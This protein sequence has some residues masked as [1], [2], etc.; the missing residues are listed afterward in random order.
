MKVR[1][2]RRPVF[3][4][5]GLLA[6]AVMLTLS[7]LIITGTALAADPT[8]A[9]AS[10]L[11]RYEQ[12]DEALSY[13][14]EWSTVSR[15]AASGHSFARADTA[16]ASVNITF[17]GTRLDWIASEDARTGLADV[18]LDG[19]FVQRVSLRAS[20]V[21]YQ[22][23][24]WS[25]GDIS[26]GVH[27]VRI[28]RSMSAPSG[29]YVTIDA[30][31]VA[32]T[33]APC[34][35]VEESSSLLA[36]EDIWAP[37][38]DPAFSG[39]EDISTCAPGAAVTVEFS[40]TYLAWV[41]QK[42]P[43]GG[44]AK[45]TVDGVHTVSVDLHGP[46]TSY[47][48]ALWD[49]GPL[50]P[51]AH[52]VKI[53]RT[54]AHNPA[55]SGTWMNVDGF[56]V[57]GTATQAYVWRRCEDDDPRVLY[58]G[59]WITIP[60]SQASGGSDERTATGDAMVTLTFTG[61]KLQW[62]AT[63]GPGL[64]RA[65]VSVD[66]GPVQIV[67][68]SGPA[69]LNEQKVWSTGTLTDGTHTVQIS[70]D[71]SSPMGTYIDV[72]AFEVLGNL[73]STKDKEALQTMWAQQKLVDLSYRPGPVDGKFGYTTRGALIAFQKW[74]GLTRNGRL[75]DEVFSRLR[76][77]ARPTPKKQG[78]S[79]AWIEVDKAKQ[80]LLY[81]RDGAVVWTLPVST[82][83]PNVGYATPSGTYKIQRKTLET[84]P[85]WHPMYIAPR[86]RY[87]AIHGYPNV[88]VVRAS[89]ACIRTQ[90]WDQRDLYPLIPVGMP[91]YVY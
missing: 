26:D 22:S 48:Q 79:E 14:G 56:L 46:W 55:S 31:D 29:T 59:T 83:S 28:V 34:L 82:G 4:A 78:G 81:C 39:G 45:V 47:Q 33:L 87:L 63:T 42:D 49:T 30:V 43:A 73:P 12:T 36:Y 3:A 38:A 54:D 58:W 69:S 8:V 76:T 80:L 11:T 53:E 5:A 17:V 44:I 65:D 41:G 21:L 70:R 64:G 2:T 37:R 6:T 15:S 67:D 62:I 7:A 20:G 32:G 51:G 24:V 18:Y 50:T 57:A 23:A 19:V 66:N 35:W 74:E 86:G 77:A 27:T 91:V 89:H 61:E 1:A 72:D 71:K 40:G 16:G 84:N 90:I 88:P 9:R 13:S 85:R 10:M 68:L 52:T 75:T 60:V 25:T